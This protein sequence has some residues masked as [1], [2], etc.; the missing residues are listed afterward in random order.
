M[1]EQDEVA[2]EAEEA[3]EEDDVVEDD[4]EVQEENTVEIM[5]PEGAELGDTLTIEHAGV[6]VEIQV[7]E[8]VLPGEMFSISYSIMADVPLKPRPPSR[9]PPGHA[10]SD[11]AA[12]EEFSE[13]ESAE[14]FSTEESEEEAK[15]NEDIGERVHRPKREEMEE[16]SAEEF[17]DEFDDCHAHEHLNVAAA[18]LAHV[19]ARALWRRAKQLAMKQVRHDRLN[20]DSDYLSW[21]ASAVGGDVSIDDM[22]GTKTIIITCPNDCSCG[23]VVA[24]PTADGPIDV[25]VPEGVGPGDTFEVMLTAVDNTSPR[26]PS[27]SPTVDDNTSPRLPSVS[28]T[29]DGD[30]SV[31][32]V[33]CPVGV[34][35]GESLWL[36]IAGIPEDVECVVPPDVEPGQEFVVHLPGDRAKLYDP[37]IEGLSLKK[38]TAAA[39]IL[40]RWRQRKIQRGM[41]KAMRGQREALEA[42]YAMQMQQ[43]IAEAELEV[44]TAADTAVTELAGE[45]KA[46]HAAEILALQVSFEKELR[47]KEEE[48]REQQEPLVELESPP[49]AAVEADAV[50][51][52]AAARAEAE[53]EAK[54]LKAE[55]A[56]VEGTNLETAHLDAANGLASA[57]SRVAA[58]RKPIVRVEKAEQKTTV[59]GTNYSMVVGP[60]GGVNVHQLGAPIK[61]AYSIVEGE[62][63]TGGGAQPQQQQR[64][65]RSAHLPSPSTAQIRA[66]RRAARLKREAVEAKQK[67]NAPHAAR[68]FWSSLELDESLMSCGKEHLLEK[69]PKP[70]PH[71]ACDVCSASGTEYRCSRGCEYATCN[72]CWREHNERCRAVALKHMD[73]LCVRF[74]AAV[75]NAG[76]SDIDAFVARMA[77]V[78]QELDGNTFS[79]ERA[80]ELYIAI[81]EGAT[82]SSKQAVNTHSA[83]RK[84]LAEL[85]LSRLRKRA[86]ASGAS[87]DLIEEVCDED[88]LHPKEALVELILVKSSE[89]IAATHI[90]R[91][92]EAFHS[93]CKFVTAAD[94]RISHSP[95]SGEAFTAKFGEA[96]AASSYRANF[97]G[98]PEKQERAQLIERQQQLEEKLAEKEAEILLMAQEK[99]L[100]AQENELIEAEKDALATVSITLAT[101]R[102]KEAQ[103][104]DARDSE[105]LCAEKLQ[106][107]H[108]AALSAL[109]AEF[110]AKSEQAQIAYAE[111][112]ESMAMEHRTSSE[113]PA[114]QST[115]VHSAS[116][117]VKSVVQLGDELAAREQT[118]VR[119]NKALEK[120]ESTANEL[121]EQVEVTLSKLKLASK[122]EAAD[123]ASIEALHDEHDKA[124]E[125]LLQERAAVVRLDDELMK[126]ESELN[127]WR[128]KAQEAAST[129]AHAIRES[130]GTAN[131]NLLAS[132]ALRQQQSE[133]SRLKEA[134]HAHAEGGKAERAE[135]ERRLA[136][137]TAVLNR[138]LVATLS[139]ASDD[140]VIAPRSTTS[141]LNRQRVTQL[142]TFRAHDFHGVFLLHFMI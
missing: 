128:T 104:T 122:N 22:D 50:P 70:T 59:S 79:M 1:M 8:G 138:Y 132:I 125:A 56:A 35:A 109:A 140:P 20:R 102:V 84:E 44:A 78:A 91:I 107:D 29:V 116:T 77:D 111:A 17:S 94:G 57:L 7:P 114:E 118:V 55:E 25:E 72:S 123:Q 48:A 33:I 100:M 80:R 74:K 139:T 13:E 134:V 106:C 141:M 92:C 27:V 58:P 47:A 119:T 38:A 19:A 68:A 66:R 4:H 26:L 65:Q 37:A 101:E 110:E 12:S 63:S 127:S 87:E 126:L 5:C 137:T 129:T 46:T 113:L 52:A 133:L 54:R 18:Q 32:H 93:A 64:L 82:D 43:I 85:K 95:A 89:V 28:S 62:E 83:L 120:A 75:L 124:E 73:G 108:E 9:F 34:S 105:V 115:P 14:D 49:S 98:T 117:E 23:D 76:L 6:E 81:V 40:G 60:G 16:E 61:R 45:I 86:L 97:V 2:E 112:L 11:H 15:A 90:E 121:A 99:A 21:L 10:V 39:S 131:V 67:K 42:K 130:E 96:L 3:E 24:L 51:T 36:E 69:N 135:L 53:A 71:R 142:R 88:A 41:M 136:A 103:Q 30:V 31:I